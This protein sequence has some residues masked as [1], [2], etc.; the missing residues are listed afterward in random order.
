M[1]ARRSCRWP[2]YRPALTSNPRHPPHDC[3]WSYL[4]IGITDRA[5]RGL[6]RRDRV[7]ANDSRT[8]VYRRARKT[9]RSAEGRNG[10]ATVAPD[11][12]TYARRLVLVSPADRRLAGTCLGA[13]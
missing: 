8:S 10:S 7:L 12:P 1:L 4:T 3:H 6:N 2:R 5:F 11:E 13:E 9:S